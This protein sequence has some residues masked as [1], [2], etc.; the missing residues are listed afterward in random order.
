M[1][2]SMMGT[3]FKG[4][5]SR[6]AAP[7]DSH[8]FKLSSRHDSDKEHTVALN[9]YQ[10]LG[11]EKSAS[12]DEIKKAYRKMASKHHPDKEGGSKE[13]FQEVEEAY[14]VLSD[15]KAKAAYDTPQR[16]QFSH[17]F[18]D[19]DDILSKMRDAHHRQRQILN[20]NMSVLDAFN[21]RTLEFTIDGVKDKVKI[22]AGIPNGS[23]GQFSTEGG[24]EITVS[25]NIVHETLRLI[26]IG[27]ARH[28]TD[29]AGNGSGVF[30]TGTILAQVEVP[31]IK[32]MTGTWVTIR[33]F[34]GMDLQV[35]VPAGHNPAQT[36]K[37]KGRGYFNWSSATNS[38]EGRGDI[39]VQVVP[40]FQATKDIAV[41]DV[42]ELV[43]IVKTKKIDE[44][45]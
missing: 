25:V 13:K 9:H 8:S 42:D 22:P 18:G 40:V 35:R 20:V 23:T 5:L 17:G 41:A 3:R 43:A 27:E 16:Q 21:G 39:L 26:H 30:N 11:I 7:T 32:L 34:S 4:V 6:T 33:D 29:G 36:L 45:A 44:Q 1:Q 28:V 38:P 31:V 15:A 19:I 10:T 14:R 24:R 12:Q 2:L 37:I